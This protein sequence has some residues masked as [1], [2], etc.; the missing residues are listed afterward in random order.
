MADKPLLKADL[1]LF[2]LGTKT[3]GVYS[4]KYTDK[5]GTAR[6]TH[7]LGE[8]EAVIDPVKRIVLGFKT[9]FGGQRIQA[10]SRDDLDKFLSSFAR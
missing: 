5:S 6:E 1:P 2:S 7:V 8:V 10:T 9:K 3:F 4:E